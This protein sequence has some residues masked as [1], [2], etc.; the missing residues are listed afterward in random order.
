MK[1]LSLSEAQA[2]LPDDK[3]A[4]LEFAV[5][6]DKTLLFALT[7][8]AATP[9]LKVFSLPIKSKD[10]T[11]R[12]QKFRQTLADPKLDLGF[13]KEAAALYDLLLKSAQTLLKG[14]TSLVIVPDGPLWEMS[15]QA[16]VLRRFQMPLLTELGNIV[17]G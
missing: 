13:K 3:T 11:A 6:E 17:P 4:L 15:F 7:K 8:A 5:A 1:S 9:D 2:L 14:K 10:L 12:A 16:L